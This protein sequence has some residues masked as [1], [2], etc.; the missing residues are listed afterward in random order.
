MNHVYFPCHHILSI[1]LSSVYQIHFLPSIFIFL[2]LILC[3]PSLGSEP[4]KWFFFLRGS[5]LKCQCWA[6]IIWRLPLGI[7]F[8]STN[9]ISDFSGSNIL[10]FSHSNY[11]RSRWFLEFSQWF[12]SNRV[13][14]SEIFLAFAS[15]WKRMILNLDWTVEYK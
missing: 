8:S 7:G 5:A 4:F 10:F 9:E 13:K 2:V 3:Y 12:E 14:V 1:Y 11:V 6:L 15:W